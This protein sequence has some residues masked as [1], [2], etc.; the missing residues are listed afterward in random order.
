MTRFF[1]GSWEP[2]QPPR[3][4]PPS[5]P[6]KTLQGVFHWYRLLLTGET[7]E[8]FFL[9]EMPP[10]KKK[11][12]KSQSRLSNGGLSGSP[13]TPLAG[14]ASGAEA[15]SEEDFLAAI[16]EASNRFPRLIGKSALVARVTDAE[17]ESAES[18]KG[19]K[20]WMSEPSMVAS[21]VAP[22]S[23]VSVISKS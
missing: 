12:S 23:I 4:P 11:Q 9:N 14:S 2:R 7:K 15:A 6:P 13:Q 10:S 5:V 1:V 16:D 8:F 22:G 21:S 3:A 17:S 19:C 20:I 18:S